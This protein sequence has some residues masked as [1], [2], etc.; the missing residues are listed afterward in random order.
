[1]SREETDVFFFL[2]LLLLFAF[3]VKTP[4][5]VHAKPLGERFSPDTHS[6]TLHVKPG[7]AAMKTNPAKK[8]SRRTESN[9]IDDG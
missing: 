5:F 7:P 8:T 2:L 4:P 3:A 9:D 6:G 1:M